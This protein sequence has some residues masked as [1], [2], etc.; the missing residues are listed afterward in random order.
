M[1]A[2]T[3]KFYELALKSPGLTDS[4]KIDFRLTKKSLLFLARIIDHGLN[5]D[6]TKE[7]DLLELL[8]ADNREDIKRTQVEILKKAELEDFYAEIN[9]I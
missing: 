4:V 3:K 6:F 9:Q 7:E 8:P 1:N 5:A 2:M